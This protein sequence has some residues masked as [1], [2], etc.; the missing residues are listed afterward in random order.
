MLITLKLL[1]SIII[2]IFLHLLC[3]ICVSLIFKPHETQKFVSH[4]KS[5]P[6]KETIKIRKAELIH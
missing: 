2:A 1:F 4:D 5:T 6:K 3:L